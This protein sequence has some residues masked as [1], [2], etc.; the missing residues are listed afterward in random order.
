MN[1]KL[2]EQIKERLSDRDTN[3]LIEIWTKN[4]HEEWPMRHL[5]RFG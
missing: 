2:V 3:Q 4:D 5:K 1:E